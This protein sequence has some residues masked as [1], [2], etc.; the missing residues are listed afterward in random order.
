MYNLTLFCTRHGEAGN[1]NIF[2]LY[3]IIVELKPE[4]IFEEIPPCLFEEH[5]QNVPKDKLESNAIKLYMTDH[6][7][8]HIPVDLDIIMPQ[9]FW[10]NHRYMFNKIE[11]I[12]SEF[13]KLCDYDSQY[14]RQ[15]GFNYLNSIYSDH[16]NK[17]KYKEMEATLNKLNDSKLFE[18]FVS[19]NKIIEKRE[20]EMI[21]NIYNYCRENTFERGIFFIGAAHRESIIEKIKKIVEIEELEIKWNY[22]EYGNNNIQLIQI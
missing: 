13:C 9:S 16:N 3:K 21:K 4:I 18:I 11:K 7:I 15:Y 19:W 17:D 8:N 14:V 1:C 22:F 6:N 2:E 5:Y 10:D 12:S 20:N